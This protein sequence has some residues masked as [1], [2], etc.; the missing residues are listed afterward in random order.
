MHLP[1][2]RWFTCTA[3]AGDLRPFRRAA[4]RR[5]I[6]VPDLS[7]RRRDRSSRGALGRRSGGERPPVR[8]RYPSRAVAQLAAR[9]TDRSPIANSHVIG[10]R[11]AVG[12]GGVVGG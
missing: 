7:S 11:R 12:A 3:P 6:A 8:A 10:G 2:P 9:R 4:T 1:P 5:G